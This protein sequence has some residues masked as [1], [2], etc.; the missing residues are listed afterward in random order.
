MNDLIA[1]EA[2]G[3]L[4]NLKGT[5]YHLL[6]AIWLLL[7]NHAE[8]FLFFERNDL[9]VRLTTPPDP[10]STESLSA[11]AVASWWL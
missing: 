4:S 6:Y 2:R 10:T 8:K 7:R 9:L 11:S 3:D 5:D 1:A